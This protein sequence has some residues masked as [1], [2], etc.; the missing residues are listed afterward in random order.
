LSIIA[1]GLLLTGI[2]QVDKHGK[3][4]EHKHDFMD[5]LI[6]VKNGLV[7]L[8]KEPTYVL[9]GLTESLL[10]STLHIFIFIWTPILRDINPKVET[11]DVFTLFM[12]SL[13]LGGA[14]FRAMF[15]FFNN[16]IFVVVKLVSF[17]C[18]VSHG[19][20]VINQGYDMT[21][22][23]FLLYEAAVGMLYPTYSKLKSEYLPSE[24]RGTL[25]NIF[26]IPLNLTIIFLLLTMKWLFTI[27]QV[28]VN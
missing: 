5:A 27:R 21:L 23:G 2:K 28:R 11:N 1:T 13:M 17:F 6:N 8:K 22:V 15:I 18:L 24:Q 25:M 20:V 3:D 9:I 10:F 4:I 26:K 12:M 7:I 19:L 14:F 16:N